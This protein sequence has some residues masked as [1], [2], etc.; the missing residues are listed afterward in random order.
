MT[1]RSAT[2][3]PYPVRVPRVAVGPLAPAVLSECSR[4]LAAKG[5]SSGSAAAVVDLA[6]R[7]SSWMHEVDVGVGGI[8]EELL[9]RF[10][11]A[12]CAR[13]RPCSSV[14]CWIGALGR[15]WQLRATCGP[16]KSTTDS[17][18]RRVPR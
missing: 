1:K 16:P 15:S 10:V 7:L 6:K 8:D 13:D 5:Y 17:S 2:A 11:A 12:E 14:N 3:R 18:L 9:A 4:W